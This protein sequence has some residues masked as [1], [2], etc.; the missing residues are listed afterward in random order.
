VT[1]II[2]GSI[3]GTGVAYR[4]GGIAPEI[5]RADAHPLAADLRSLG[6]PKA[7]FASASIR[8]AHMSFGVAREFEPGAARTTP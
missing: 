2:E 6:L 3:G 7:P 1:R 5:G 4:L 8:H